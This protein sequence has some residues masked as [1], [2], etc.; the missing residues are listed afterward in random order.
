MARNAS[1]S[2][3]ISGDS[4]PLKQAQQ[5]ALADT[6]TW[7]NRMTGINNSVLKSYSSLAFGGIPSGRMRSPIAQMADEDAKAWARRMADTRRN[8]Q[9]FG[10]AMRSGMGDGILQTAY[11]VDDLQYGLRGIMNNIPGLVQSLGGGAGLAGVL[12][13]VAVAA[14]TVGK[15]FWDWW[16]GAKKLKEVT[17]WVEEMNGKLKEAA[18]IRAQEALEGTAEGAASLAAAVE[19]ANDALAKQQALLATNAG[20]SKELAAAQAALA[21]AKI[22]GTPKDQ[23]QAQQRVD[24]ELAKAQH[25]ATM[26]Q[27]K[28]EMKAHADRA[29]ALDKYAAKAEIAAENARAR[30]AGIGQDADP[31]IRETE[32]SKAEAAAVDAA[33][34]RAEAVKAH[35]ASLEEQGR[36]AAEIAHQEKVFALELDEIWTR[37]N[38][39][40]SETEK[41]QS[42]VAAAEKKRIQ[43]EAAA[44]DEKRRSEAAAK[45]EERRRELEARQ[46]ELER[47]IGREARADGRRAGPEISVERG[48]RI[49]ARARPA[50]RGHSVDEVI[51]N[52]S[53]SLRGQ[54]DDYIGQVG[55]RRGTH[56]TDRQA[57]AAHQ[58]RVQKAREENPLLT[59]MAAVRK[60]LA[61]INKNTAG[62]SKSKSE[63][64]KRN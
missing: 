33:K 19:K 29:Q 15:K 56:A 1:I 55:G 60:E 45:E 34:A 27:L 48:R 44:G 22:S 59:E 57:A 39:R 54:L 49:N 2:A 47:D 35:N 37:T 63:P 40:V 58:A 31:F 23:A 9:A 25:A 5:Q 20:N 42:D 13:I 62:M 21:E 43:D 8:S 32:N 26:E 36:L 4:K 3:R 16:V 52:R 24:V 61:E 10:N 7:V 53:N 28:G 18:S 50:R 11:A 38:K 14:G 64:L 30:A 6:Q 41:A 17:A 46:R 51:A 12:A